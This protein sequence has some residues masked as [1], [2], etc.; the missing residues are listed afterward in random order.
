MS[1]AKC[2]LP[3]ARC[4]IVCLRCVQVPVCETDG[5]VY[6][7]GGLD[8]YQMIVCV[9]C[10]GAVRGGCASDAMCVCVCMCVIPEEKGKGDIRWVS[11]SW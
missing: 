11:D 5:C 3:N 8:V 6:H 1:Q 2:V 7:K 4:V 9:S 10:V